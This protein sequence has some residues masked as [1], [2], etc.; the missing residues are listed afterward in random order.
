MPNICQF[1]ICVYL[2]K[3]IYNCNV[4]SAKKN[5]S[6][7]TPVKSKTENIITQQPSYIF[8]DD[9]SVTTQKNDSSEEEI[10]SEESDIDKDL[11]DSYFDVNLKDVL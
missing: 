8:Q 10:L 2:V 4:T 7:I 9:Y 1:F 6:I 11:I 5:D 3:I